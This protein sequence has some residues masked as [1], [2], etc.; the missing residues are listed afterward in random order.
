MPSYLEIGLRVATQPHCATGE[1]SFARQPRPGALASCPD[2][3]V[4]A[5]LAKC[6]SPLCAG[7]YDVEP[8]VPIHPP[9]CG[10]EYLERWKPEG[11][12]Q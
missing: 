8:G 12:V 1:E 6:G 3:A 2:I 5:N 9:K 4:P 11:K 10:K 7:C